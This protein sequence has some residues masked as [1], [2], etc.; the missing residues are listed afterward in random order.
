MNIK[1]LSAALVA[2][3][4]GGGRVQGTFTGTGQSQAGEGP[5]QIANGRF[6]LPLRQEP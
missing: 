3:R 2:A 1:L 6:D 4:A 5:I